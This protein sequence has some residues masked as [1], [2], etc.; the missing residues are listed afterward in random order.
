MFVYPL[1][2]QLVMWAPACFDSMEAFSRL[3]LGFGNRLHQ[4]LHH[5]VTYLSSILQV[6]P[7]T[8]QYH[9]WA[10]LWNFTNFPQVC[11]WDNIATD[12]SVSFS[13]YAE[14][15]DWLFKEEST[16]TFNNYPKIQ[17]FN[18]HENIHTISWIHLHI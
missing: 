9:N 12:R 5:A 16:F 4:V 17:K 3:V 2:I 6:S 18:S 10:I 13:H 1:K 11:L 15:S 7:N 14:R 8:P